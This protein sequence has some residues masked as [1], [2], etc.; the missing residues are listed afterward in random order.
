MAE[1]KRKTFAQRDLLVDPKG[2]RWVVEDKGITWVTDRVIILR[3]DLFAKT[4]APLAIQDDT[5][6]V[7][8][9]TKV[10]K[11]LAE[12]RGTGPMPH[13][14]N[15]KG[16]KGGWNPEARIY[17]AR[18]VLIGLNERVAKTLRSAGLQPRYIFPGKV[19]W[20]GTV[21]GK[22]ALYA[23]QMAV[24]FYGVRFDDLAEVQP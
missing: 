7:L 2:P 21:R 5:V 9:K 11:I 16:V 4:P 22:P 6:P 8:S 24:G 1:P 17:E 12:A 20:Y 3:A 14:T 10:R 23:M 19:A 13:P 18:G 15:I